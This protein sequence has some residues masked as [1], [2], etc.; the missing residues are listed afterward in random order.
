MSLND[1]LILIKDFK[2]Q[3]IKEEFFCY[4]VTI[5]NKKGQTILKY[6]AYNPKGEAKYS[7]YEL[8]EGEYLYIQ[9]LHSFL[10]NIRR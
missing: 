4:S 3:D 5:G 6:R 10:G 7:R 2:T 1:T 8:K 9:N